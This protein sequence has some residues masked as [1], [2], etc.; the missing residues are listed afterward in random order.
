MENSFQVVPSP[1]GDIRLEA[2][3]RGITGMYFVGQGSAG[4]DG[5]AGAGLHPHL[6]R[7]REQL[8]AY[9]AGDLTAFDLPLAP[10]GTDFQQ[11]VWQ[12]LL[13]IP[14]GGTLSYGELAASIG[15]PRAR[16]GR[17]VGAAVG[18]NPIAIVVPCHRVVGSGGALTGYAGGLRRKRQ[19]LALEAR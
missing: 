10:A 7:C 18:R 16:Y 2:N 5:T 8:Q 17:A 9:F 3:E 6:R 12:A 4:G 13:A 14:Y 15:K 1:C 19:L 11:Q